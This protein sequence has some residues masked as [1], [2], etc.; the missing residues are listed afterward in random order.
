MAVIGES[1]P[2]DRDA[3]VGEQAAAV[4]GDADLPVVAGDDLANLEAGYCE[5]GSGLACNEA[6]I[7]QARRH[8]YAAAGDAWQRGCALGFA[9]ACANRNATSVDGPLDMGPPALDDLPILVRGSKGPIADRSPAALGAAAC[10]AGWMMF[11]E[12][13]ISEAP[14]G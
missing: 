1:S 4:P 12:A 11:C 14:S 5:S 10:R 6:G 9:A 13:F 7:V 8:N 2:S 3:A